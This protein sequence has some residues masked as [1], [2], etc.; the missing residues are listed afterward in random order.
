MSAHVRTFRNVRRSHR[1]IEAPPLYDRLSHSYSPATS[2]RLGG[3]R[4]IPFGSCLCNP[5]GCS[6]GAVPS[7]LTSVGL[8]RTL[9][10]LSCAQTSCMFGAA[11]YT[12]NHKQGAAERGAKTAKRGCGIKVGP[13]WSCGFRGSA[14]PER[15]ARFCASPQRVWA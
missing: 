6:G 7:A 15:R 8:S 5:N 14:L 12:R 13:G 4:S 10:P 3:P 2:S 11:E 1:Q 9:R